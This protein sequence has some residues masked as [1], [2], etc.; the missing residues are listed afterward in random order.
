MNESW[1]R[2]AG[3]S[4][5]MKVPVLTFPIGASLIRIGHPASISPA[6]PL[7]RNTTI[8]ALPAFGGPRVCEA[9]VNEAPFLAGAAQPE[10]TATV[11][12]SNVARAKLTTIPRLPG[13]TLGNGCRKGSCEELPNKEPFIRHSS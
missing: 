4:A 5:Y 1:R 10:I 3:R 13:E 12:N 7:S 6:Y 8:R 11:R 9:A 2:P